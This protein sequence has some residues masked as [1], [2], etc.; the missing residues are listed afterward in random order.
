MI[1]EGALL[2][3]GGGAS[4]GIH[5]ASHIATLLSHTWYAVEPSSALSKVKS[6]CNRSL[7]YFIRS[8]A[9][10]SWFVPQ[11]TPWYDVALPQSRVWYIETC[12]GKRQQKLR[13]EGRNGGTRYLFQK[14]K[15][16]Y[17]IR[18]P[19]FWTLQRAESSRD[20]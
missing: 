5:S 12:F 17:D 15:G 20:G 13:K 6:R 8:S 18:R 9:I 11:S 16:K 1:T 2:T 19:R 3:L 7:H 10:L 14:P 4:Q